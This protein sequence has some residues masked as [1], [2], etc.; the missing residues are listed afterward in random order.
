VGEEIMALKPPTADFDWFKVIG[1]AAILFGGVQAY[2]GQKEQMNANT[3]R[4]AKVEA[5]LDSMT[6]MNVRMARLEVKLDMIMQQKAL[7]P[8][9]H[10]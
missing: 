8:K 1:A 2:G 7:E 3:A 4:I 10:E 6:S 5:S 9:E